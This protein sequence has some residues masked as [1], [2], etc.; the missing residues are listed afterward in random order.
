MES[1]TLLSMDTYEDWRARF[2][3]P[4][5]HTLVLKDFGLLID[6]S[7]QNIHHLD[8]TEYVLRFT[9][10]EGG[11]RSEPCWSYYFLQTVPNLVSLTWTVHT[12]TVELL[13]R[14][15]VL[16]FLKFLS[17]PSCGTHKYHTLWA[18]K[19]FVAPSLEYLDL[20]LGPCTYPGLEETLKEALDVICRDGSVQLRHLT[21]RC[22]PKLKSVNFRAMSPHLDH[23]DTFTIRDP[24]PSPTYLQPHPDVE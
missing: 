11:L 5:L 10:I 17:L 21:L 13:P 24:S 6:G 2:S 15:M 23:L 16:P 3:F 19:C 20:D 14:P 22:P 1:L 9:E 12:S 18:L 7:I 4:R 8:M